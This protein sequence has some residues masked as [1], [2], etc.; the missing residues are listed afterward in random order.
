MHSDQPRIIE[1]NRTIAIPSIG[2]QFCSRHMSSIVT[3]KNSH[4]VLISEDGSKWVIITLIRIIQTISTDS[5]VI[6]FGV[7]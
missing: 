5:I 4:T 6:K 2:A 3:E 7:V 1:E